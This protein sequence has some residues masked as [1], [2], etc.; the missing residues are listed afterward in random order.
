MTYTMK[1]FQRQYVR[2]HFA[3][4]TPEE[5][6]DILRSLPP[7]EREEVL[8]GLTLEQRL[9][10]LS[11]EEIRQYLDRLSTGGRP[12]PRRPRRKK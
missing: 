7:K 6:Q 10:G 3:E 12:S 2:E 9:A 11:V 4:L 5:R 1:D 8:Q